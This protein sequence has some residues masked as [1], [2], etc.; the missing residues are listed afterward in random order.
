[1]TYALMD[2]ALTV[3]RTYGPNGTT[4]HTVVTSDELR[5]VTVLFLSSPR[6]TTLLPYSMT[7]PLSSK[8]GLFE[9]LDSLSVDGCSRI[10]PE[11]SNCQSL[12]FI[13][14]H[15]CFD[16]LELP[17][18]IVPM[19]S[20]KTVHI[21]KGDWN[22]EMI[23]TFLYWLAKFA[24]NLQSFVVC[25]QTQETAN[26]FMYGLMTNFAFRDKFKDKLLHIGFHGCNL[27][28]VDL[29]DI[30]FD[31][32]PLYEKLDV[33]NLTNND[34][35]GLNTLRMTAEELK[36][37]GPIS[38][39]LTSLILNGNPVL[40]NLKYYENP[41]HDAMVCVLQI[42]PYLNTI[43]YVLNDPSSAS[44][45]YWL[46]INKRRANKHTFREQQHDAHS[47]VRHHP[48]PVH[49]MHIVLEH[50]NEKEGK[51]DKI[52][53]LLL[54]DWFPNY[55]SSLFFLSDEDKRKRELVFLKRENKKLKEENNN[56]KQLRK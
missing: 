32:R 5:T 53:N 39:P 40:A 8:I 36:I 19:K 9:E 48:N 18:D 14:L 31:M 22:K 52:F 37:N 13:L 29:R 45:K 21:S 27:T 56:L 38:S 47:L 46:M 30:M 49:L 33:L 25:L 15:N 44:I 50:A 42:F 16:K 10:P 4:M 20:L 43:Q 12:D 34:V 28:E 24:P 41:D 7:L 54:L 26:L 51:E 11:I 35:E 23:R 2:L 3:R 17:Q 1:M 55:L 6:G